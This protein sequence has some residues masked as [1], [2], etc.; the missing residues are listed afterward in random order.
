[1]FDIR[2]MPEPL[3]PHLRDLAVQAEPATIGHFRLLG[4]P[5]SGIRPL[6][7]VPRIAGPAVT[8]ALPAS[9]STLLHHAVGMLRPG[10]VVVIDRLG[11]NRHACLGGGVAYAI[12]KAGVAAVIVDGPCADPAEIREL[13]LPVWARGFSSITTRLQGIG[14][15]MNV[16]VSCGGA[17]VAPG[18][19]VIADEGG[20]VFMPRGEGPAQCEQALKLQRM[21][22]QG[23]PLLSAQ[24]PLGELTGASELVRAKLI[25]PEC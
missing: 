7:T 3:P 25:K 22:Q 20:I 18:D 19:L 21:E 4:F 9:D 10:D 2:Q 1:M 23:L 15:A 14:G 5:D 16:P 24:R 12:A 8:L 6:F 13:G 17:V 11:D